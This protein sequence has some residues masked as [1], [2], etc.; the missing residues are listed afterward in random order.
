MFDDFDIDPDE[1]RIKRW[2]DASTQTSQDELYE[3]ASNIVKNYD[4]IQNQW[5]KLHQIH[6]ESREQL[7]EQ[8]AKNS[9]IA[10]IISGIGVG[11]GIAFGTILT[12]TFLRVI[13]VKDE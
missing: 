1:V 4:A 13:F 2:T 12:F 3:K 5:K 10:T 6:R 11:L 8:S 9:A 7:R